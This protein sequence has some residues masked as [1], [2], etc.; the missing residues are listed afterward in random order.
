MHPIAEINS[1]R[2]RGPKPCVYWGVDCKTV[3]FVLEIAKCRPMTR[4]LC[5]PLRLNAKV[6]PP[7]A[8]P[9]TATIVVPRTNLATSEE[10]AC[11]ARKCSVAVH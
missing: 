1:K 3:E 7:V 8:S 11:R 10:S 9:S 2:T 4:V 5:S 6:V